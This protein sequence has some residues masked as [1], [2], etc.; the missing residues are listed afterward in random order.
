MTPRERLEHALTSG[1]YALLRL[2]LAEYVP[3]DL[4]ELY[5][6]RSKLGR[7]PA[8]TP[9]AHNK[10]L[11]AGVR[12]YRVLIT[13]GADEG[14]ALARVMRKFPSVSENTWIDAIDGK[15]QRVNALLE[16]PDVETPGK[17]KEVS[18]G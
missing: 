11:A 7:R 1:R 2:A 17:S 6:E 4:R 15:R 18:V 14:D 9:T 8:K 5:L 12:L 10:T 3:A 16:S 13:Q